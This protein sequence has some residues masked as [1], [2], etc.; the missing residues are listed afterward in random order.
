MVLGLVN[1]L[2]LAAAWPYPRLR[3]LEDELPDVEVA[4]PMAQAVG[5]AS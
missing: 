5:E 4:A 3:Q 2:V 1:L